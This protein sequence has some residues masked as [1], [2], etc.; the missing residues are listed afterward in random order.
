MRM[1]VKGTAPAALLALGVM[2]LGSGT[3]LADTDGGHSVGG[4]NQIQAPITL[5]VDISGNAAAVGGK[6]TA[7]SQGGASATETGR[8]PGGNTTSGRSS[9]L[10]GNQVNAPI[11]APVNACGNAISLAGD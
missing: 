1:W 3:A 7:V 10:G 11:T 6:S 5:P 2:S 9:V 8:K 4:G